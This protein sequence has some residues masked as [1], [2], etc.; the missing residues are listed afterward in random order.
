MEREA[1]N[2]RA[3]TSRAA[4]RS[5]GT[6]RAEETRRDRGQ[7]TGPG[8]RVGA[9]QPDVDPRRVVLAPGRP[10]VP[11]RCRRAD[12]GP[13]LRRGAPP[14]R[15]GPLED[16]QGPARGGGRRVMRRQ[17]RATALDTLERED[18]ALLELFGAIDAPGEGRPAN[19]GPTRR[20]SGSSRHLAVREAALVEVAG[21]ADDVP[22]V[23]L[24]EQ[25]AAGAAVRRALAVGDRPSPSRP[26]PMFGVGQE[27]DGPLSAVMA[28]VRDQVTWERDVAIPVIERALG[29]RAAGPVRRRGVHRPRTA[30]AAPGDPR[31]FERAPVVSPAPHLVRPPARRPG[32]GTPRRRR[33]RR[34]SRRSLKRRGG[35]C[36]R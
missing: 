5:G 24:A 10:P 6:P 21:P 34:L 12:P 19:G 32:L 11:P 27:F 2:G 36:P 28:L 22:G 20:R 16:E 33:A 17:R 25:F 14:G 1:S 31:W 18:R 3:S 29:G 9:G 35:G 26:T 23:G 13:A 7:G 8:R 30:A 15:G 4:G